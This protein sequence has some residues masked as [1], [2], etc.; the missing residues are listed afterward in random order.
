MHTPLYIICPL[1]R[2]TTLQGDVCTHA[3]MLEAG[4]VQAQLPPCTNS[5]IA[6]PTIS[7][8]VH[9]M[10]ASESSAALV[11]AAPCS[12]TFRT[13]LPPALLEQY[14]MSDKYITTHAVGT[15]VRLESSD[16]MPTHTD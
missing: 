15:Q 4:S 12:P 3:Y 9:L 2:I 16:S 14:V 5:E 13:C 7:L 10:Q 8:W 11:S 1:V 6:A